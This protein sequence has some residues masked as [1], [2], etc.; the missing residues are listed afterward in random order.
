MMHT[1]F[2]KILQMIY[3]G[4]AEYMIRVHFAYVLTTFVWCI[5]ACWSCCITWQHR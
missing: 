1:Y 4:S 3:L 2:V 5:I